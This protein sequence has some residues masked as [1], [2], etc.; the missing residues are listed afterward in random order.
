MHNLYSLLVKAVVHCLKETTVSL[1]SIYDFQLFFLNYFRLIIIEMNA[2]ACYIFIFFQEAFLATLGSPQTNLLRGHN[3]QPATINHINMWKFKWKHDKLNHQI[4]ACTS[5]FLLK[6]V[7]NE[8]EAAFASRI[9]L[10]EGP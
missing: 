3:Q 9:N 8:V 7:T 2:N 1:T 5:L 10:H 4:Y 6:I